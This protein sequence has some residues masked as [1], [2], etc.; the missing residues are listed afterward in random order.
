VQVFGIG[1]GEQ[2]H[3][4]SIP[5]LIERPLSKGNRTTVRNRNAVF[6]ARTVELD[7]DVKHACGTSS[8]PPTMAPR[9]EIKQGLNAG[10][11]VILTPRLAIA[12]RMPVNATDANA[13][14]H[15]KVARQ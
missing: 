9:F 15:Q 14:E 2:F 4:A 8:L 5:R 12:D 3:I 1:V 13:R 6:V 7:R 10:E 11:R